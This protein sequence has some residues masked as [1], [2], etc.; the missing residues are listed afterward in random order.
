MNNISTNLLELYPPIEPYTRH[1]LAV[2]LPHHLYIEECGNPQG[3]PILYLHGGPGSGCSEDSRRFFDPALYRIILFD[4]RGAGKSTPTAELQHNNTQALITD[5]ETIR[6]LLKIE[7]W[8]LFGGSWGSTLSLLYAQTYPQHVLALILRSIFLAR[9]QDLD[10]LFNGKG[11]NHVFPDYW[12]EFI[13]AIPA[14][15]HHSP[16]T[17]YYQLLTQNNEQIRLNAAK[18]WANWEGNCVSL[19]PRPVTFQLQQACI[20]C[21][22][23]VN[24]CFLGPNQILA[25]MGKIQHIPG[26]IIHGR[27]DMVCLLENAWML[28]QAWPKSAL[29]IIPSAGH[30]GSEPGIR[31]ALI[32][33]TRKI[34]KTL[35][36]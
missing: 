33:A 7:R 12:Q 9:Q 25:N 17:H 16:A 32:R 29:N 14:S 31:D 18:S 22:Y 6:Q 2:E 3:I 19:Q 8:I 24:N 20:E 13:A 23:V 34:A 4:Q 36:L 1:Y 35:S 21:H 26:I 10:W 28:H 11:L 5:I 30:S 15:H 27:Y